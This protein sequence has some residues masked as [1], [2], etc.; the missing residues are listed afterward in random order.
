[1]MDKP[2]FLF[3][4][5]LW[6][7]LV[8][9]CS[10]ENIAPLDVAI[11]DCTEEVLASFNMV[12]YEEQQ[13]DCKSFLELYEY[14]NEQYFLLGNHCIDMVSSPFDCARNILCQKGVD[15]E[16]CQSFRRD[17]VYIGIIGI[18]E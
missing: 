4:I 13:I 17:A 5:S 7:C 8:S 10:Q 9:A 14:Q 1:M 6:L 3:Y 12:A 18:E 11:T 16:L 2:I 15:I